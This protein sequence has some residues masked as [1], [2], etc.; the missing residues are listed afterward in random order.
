MGATKSRVRVHKQRLVEAL[1]FDPAKAA[2]LM[3]AS[4]K[5]LRAMTKDMAL[6]A[7]FDQPSTW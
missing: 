2:E 3:N 4:G 5:M 1:V 7:L 6:Q